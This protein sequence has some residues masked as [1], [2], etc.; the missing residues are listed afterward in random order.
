MG[1]IAISQTRPE[2]DL[3]SLGPTCAPIS[4]IIEAST[5]GFK[6]LLPLIAKEIARIESHQMGSMPMLGLHFLILKMLLFLLIPLPDSTRLSN[7]E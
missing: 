2:I 6:I 4:T 7:F 3:I 5:R 1:S